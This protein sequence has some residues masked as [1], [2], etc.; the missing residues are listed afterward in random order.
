VVVLG[1]AVSSAS[2]LALEELADA[3]RFDLSV[4]GIDSVLV[5]PGVHR[6]RM[7]EKSCSR[8]KPCG[9]VRFYR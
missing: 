7:L 9:P 4:F 2:G 6:T 3:F 1:F 5:E 8:G